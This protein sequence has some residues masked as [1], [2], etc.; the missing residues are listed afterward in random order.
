[1]QTISK[2]ITLLSV[3][4]LTASCASHYTLSGI[5]RTRI[6]IDER[7]DAAPDAAAQ[8]LIAPYKARVDSL[9]NPVVGQAGCYLYA[10]RPE[11][12]MSNLLPDIMMW[13]SEQ[14]GEA[15]DFA[16]YNI[17]GMRAALAQGDVTVGDV[18]EV[19]PFENRICFL[20]LT[21]EKVQELFEQIA[22]QGG[23]GVSRGVELVITKDG[24][25]VSG[26]LKGKPIDTKAK[27]RI[28]TL[29]YV[30]Q[31]NDRM[32]AF[33]D[34]TDVNQPESEQNNLRYI[35]MD[36]FRDQVRQ[37]KAVTAEVEGRVKI[38]Q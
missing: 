17:G 20:T 24:K 4:I 28:A 25:L 10:T 3:L 21:G 15:P 29:D 22:I 32:E 37:G 13:A 27:Y 18:L 23:E 38:Q 8:A 31:G 1:M 12:P 14:Y 5:E 7:F 36:Y 26:R 6:L 2:A 11:S 35:I 34:K 16:V 9:M 19:A 33:R 30:A